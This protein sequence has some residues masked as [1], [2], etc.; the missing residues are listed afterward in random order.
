VLAQ[1][2]RAGTPK[3]SPEH[4]RD[5][6]RVVE[7]AGDRDE[8]R[9]EVERDREIDEREGR[10]ELPPRRHTRVGEEALEENS[11]VGHEPGDHPDVPLP[12]PD[13]E[14]GDEPDVDDEQ[15]DDG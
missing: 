8:V 9:N 13:D 6:D 12:R 4:Q 1:E 15:H 10:R 11:A 14:R 2:P 3:Q 7:L 5:E